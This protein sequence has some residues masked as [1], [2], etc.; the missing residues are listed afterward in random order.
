MLDPTY[1]IAKTREEQQQVP[2]KLLF[3]HSKEINGRAD[4]DTKN[5]ASA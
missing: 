5:L 3:Y 4:Y 2:S 1:P